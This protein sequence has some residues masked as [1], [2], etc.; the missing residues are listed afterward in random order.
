MTWWT[1][2]W[3]PW[4]TSVG[5]NPLAGALGHFPATTRRPSFGAWIRFTPRSRPAGLGG[6]RGLARPPSKEPT[7][8]FRQ[9]PS[10]RRGFGRNRGEGLRRSGVCSPA[11]AACWAKVRVD[12]HDL[13]E[14]AVDDDSAFLH[15]ADL[16]V[17]ADRGEAVGDRDD[18]DLA[19]EF[20][21]GLGDGGFGGGVQALVASSSTS[22]KGSI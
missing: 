13:V 6:R 9:C 3:P 11:R 19:V 5:L 22:T 12:A 14:G 20:A 16:I 8:R 10:P 18:S 17:V 15:E 7:Q 4:K 2:S 1:R 21:D